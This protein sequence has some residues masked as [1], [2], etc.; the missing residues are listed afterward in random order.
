MEDQKDLNTEKMAEMKENIKKKQSNWE[1]LSPVFTEY[2][3]VMN[4]YK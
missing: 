2:E 3:D 4:K 1:K